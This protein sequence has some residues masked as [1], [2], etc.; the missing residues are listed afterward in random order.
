[1]NAVQNTMVNFDPIQAVRLI[2]TPY[3]DLESIIA[4]F[5][6]NS[7]PLNLVDEGRLDGYIQK[8]RERASFWKSQVELELMSSEHSMLSML[9][10]E[11]IHQS[12][13]LSALKRIKEEVRRVTNV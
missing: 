11:E 2:G 3:E 4:L 12:H 6:H 10:K 9:E 13:T 8:S 7:L 1:M 5:E